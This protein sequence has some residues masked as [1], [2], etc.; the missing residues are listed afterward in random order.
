MV[1]VGSGNWSAMAQSYATS[2][3]RAEMPPVRD[4][5]RDTTVMKSY[6]IIRRESIEVVLG[7]AHDR[8]TYAF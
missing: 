6:F 2:L 8:L 1:L 7:N 5:W 4:C 3:T